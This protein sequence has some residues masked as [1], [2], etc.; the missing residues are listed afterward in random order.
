[1]FS[2]QAF[3]VIT[4]VVAILLSIAKVFLEPEPEL[5]D[6]NLILESIESMFLNSWNDY[7][8]YGYGSD[9]Y[10]PISHN[11]RNFTGDD[12]PMGWIIVDSLDTMMQMYNYTLA[13][14][15]NVTL[16]KTTDGSIDQ[17]KLDSIAS[18]NEQFKEAIL[19]AQ[20]WIQNTLDYDINAPVNVF[21]TTI[22]MLGGLLSAYYYSTELQIG[23]PNVYLEKAV[24]LGDRLILSLEYSEIGIPYSSINL[25]TG[26]PI[27]N[28]V[29]DGASST[30]EFTTLQLEFKYLSFLTQNDKYWKLVEKV[31]KPLYENNNLTS[32][33]FDGLIPIYTVPE[34]GKFF[35]E[36]IRLGSRG[37]SFY[38]YLLKQYLLTHEQIYY[39][40]YRISIEG[41][42][43]HLVSKSSINGIVFIGEKEFGL[44]SKGLSPK[45]DHL[46]CFIGGVLAM[47][48]T[49][50]LPIE[51]AKE[52]AFWDEK[53]QEDWD[54][55]QEITFTCYQMYDQIPSGLAPEIVVFD[56]G[57]SDIST[58]NWYQSFYNDFYVKPNDAHNLQ[59]PEAVESLMFMY[60]LTKEKKYR[61]WGYQILQKF[62][63][64]A[65]IKDENDTDDS[66][67][68]YTSLENCFDVPT[69]KRDNLESF[70]LAETLKYFHLLFQDDV[71]LTKVVYN[72]EAHPFPVLDP[73]V[74]EEMS[75]TT[76][77]TLDI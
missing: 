49:E 41:V 6:N 29:D 61:Q 9:I 8:Q 22:R 17:S 48:A 62:K 21:E 30:A 43:K 60:H 38:E 70:W 2:N 23:N 50:G 64:N 58:N 19:K 33:H 40:L 11:H 24:D 59:R 31:Y 13:E 56:D 53:R 74:L 46:V 12:K 57:T 34:T 28:H 25:Q 55:A 72:T 35:G 32:P 66:T 7:T 51:V 20:D 47:G 45:M 5:P 39:D 63:E 37:D 3:A 71:D 42:K 75:L 68:R 52:Q 27:R 36:N 76:G 69:E 10:A 44:D 54:L 4:A 18:R 26:N 14:N 1:M 73:K 67:I 15:V 16:Y 77:W 65:S